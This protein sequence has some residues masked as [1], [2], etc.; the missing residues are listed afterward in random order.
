MPNET[1]PSIDHQRDMIRNRLLCRQWID[2]AELERASGARSVAA[3]IHELR[4]V[5]G[6]S[7]DERN[8]GNEYRLAPEWAQVGKSS[9]LGNPPS[10]GVTGSCDPASGRE[11]LF[12]AD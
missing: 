6:L 2:L 3:R 8:N 9:E 12:G 1:T 4:T 10:P 5:D 7:I 11:D